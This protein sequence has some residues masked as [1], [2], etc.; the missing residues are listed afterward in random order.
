MATIDKTPPP[1]TKHQLQMITLDELEV[2][3]L[4]VGLEYDNIHIAGEVTSKGN[5]IE[6]SGV[7]YKNLLTGNIEKVSFRFASAKIFVIRRTKHDN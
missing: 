1:I 7:H 2:G 4:M 6:G 3:D 5:D